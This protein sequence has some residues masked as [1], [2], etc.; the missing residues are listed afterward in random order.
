MATEAFFDETTEQSVVKAEIVAKYFWA[1]A[2]VIMPSA[3]R[4]G[5][6]IAYVDLFAEPGRYGDGTTSTPIRILEQAIA[7]PDMSRMLVSIF[8]D[9]D[10]ANTQSLESAIG[11]LAGVEGLKHRPKVYNQ[12]VGTEIIKLFEP[13]QGIPTLFFIDP[14]GYK[15]LSLQLVNAAVRDWGCDCIFFFNYNRINMGL[16]NEAVREH[17]DSL[18]GQ[19]QADGLRAKLEPLGPPERE[20][21]IVEAIGQALRAAG[22]RFVLPFCFKTASGRRTSHH[23]IFVSKS[24]KGYEIMKEIMAQASTGSDQGVPSFE[25]CPADRRQPMLFQLTRPLSDVEGML[26]Q[27]FA[28]RVMTVQQVYEEHSVGTPYIKR[29]YKEVLLGLEA[30]GKIRTDP[31]RRKKNTLA[32]HVRVE[33]PRKGT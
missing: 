9:K 20:A 6:P 2:K 21:V 17:M 4:Q 7:D 10:E 31:A 12:D 1:W 13:M 8:N 24:F 11:S 3:K 26:L 16:S 32:D 30:A 18:F 29:N 23:L 15:G 5:K 33:F 22:P 28:G 27:Q 25:Y 19:A 14:W